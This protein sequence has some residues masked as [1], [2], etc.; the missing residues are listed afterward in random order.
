MRV[1]F[2]DLPRRFADETLRARV[3][4]VFEHGQFVLG[5]E[6]THF[7][8]RF[9]KVSGARYA[10]GLN[11]G[12]DALFLA[13]KALRIGA[14][15]EVVT[16]PNSFVATAGA[17]V[18]TGARPVFVD[19]DAEY[20]MDVRQ[21]AAAITPRTRAIMPVH[22]TGNVVDVDAIAAIAAP[23]GIAVIEDAAQAVGAALRGRTVGSLGDAAA[24]SLFPLK[25]LGV[26][27]D[28]GMLTTDRE[29][30]RARVALLRHHGLRT[31]DECA[32]FA[33]NSRLD[34]LHAVVGDVLLDDLDPIT[35]KRIAHARFYDDALAGL[36]PELIVPPRRRDVKQV[37]HTYV[38]QVADRPG[39]ET[40]LAEQGIET[41]IH[42]P[43]P[44]HLQPAAASLGYR[45]GDFPVTESQSERIL[46]LPV[47]EY[48]EPAQLEWVAD[49]VRSFYRR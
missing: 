21:L 25:N 7:E 46:S 17:I 36:E 9:A 31:R 27:G 34:T 10:L 30:V 44:I 8:A 42:Y 20:L 12:T 1:K 43:I 40:Y 5:A 33:Y 28:G 11:S 41:K 26:A 18:M 24:F 23:R 2:I 16:A 19:V 45:R 49:R 13:L 47:H 38:V 29:D 48:L 4:A 37:F 6:L 35:D 14:G 22:L 3:T 32:E 15:D 39:L